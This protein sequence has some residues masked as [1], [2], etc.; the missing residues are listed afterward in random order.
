LFASFVDIHVIEF[1]KRGLPHAHILLTLAHEDKPTCAEEIDS[2][3]C[4]ELPE[5]DIDPLAYDTVTRHMI[6]GPCGPNFLK[7]PCMEGSDCSKH[8]PKPFCDETRIEEN[9]FVKYRRRDDG[10][11]ITINGKKLDNRWVVSY[12]H[13]LCVKYDAHINVE[14]CAQKN[15]IKYLHK[16]MHK[17]PDRA[18]FVIEDNVDSTDAGGHPQCRE[19]DEI[20]QYLDGRYISSIET[21]WPIF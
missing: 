5:Q 4:A 1:H 13:D 16:Y 21:A 14:R 18:T 3:I 15:V 11:R 6:H 12:N 8:Y 20:K 9:G 19:V 2:F 10:R 7:D 17:G